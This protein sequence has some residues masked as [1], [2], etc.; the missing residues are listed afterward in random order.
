MYKI[1]EKFLASRALQIVAAAVCIMFLL[2]FSKSEQAPAP[3]QEK[4][5]LV[6]VQ[7]VV[8]TSDSP[9]LML[10]G[11][12]QS[13]QDAQLSAAI[14]S[15]VIEMLINDGDTVTKGSPLVKL[16]ARDTQLNLMT[17]EADLKEAT[18]QY[19]LS[20]VKQKQL[21]NAYDKEKVL[22]DITQSK[23][24]RS[25]N[26]YDQKSI[27]RNDFDS[28]TENLTRQ[29]LSVEQAEF[30]VAENNTRT[31]ELEAKILRFT[32]MR[33]KAQLDLERATITAPF[34]GIIS[35]LAISIGDRVRNGDELMRLQ[36]P[37]ALEV[38]TQIPSRYALNV[39]NNLQQGELIPATITLGNA[40]L[41]GKVIRVSGQTREGTGGVDAFI[42]FDTT[43]LGLSLGSTIRL[44]LDLPAV[45]NIIAVSAEAIYGENT[46][47]KIVDGRMQ[48]IEVD[49]IGEKTTDDGRTLVLI[50]SGQLQ[51]GEKV[52]LTKLSNASNGLL[53]K[54]ANTETPDANLADTQ[55]NE[56]S[57]T[58]P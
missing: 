28:A 56:M 36:N 9:S 33:D 19:K 5:W 8:P 35:D 51:Q 2:I 44:Q 32:A 45:D 12:V 57:A 58:S 16:D 29:Q 21:V 24:K 15:V 13:P 41:N 48:M 31:I 55:S 3:K 7:T 25:K 10:F 47:F 43:P 14:E 4:S 22:L 38:R 39:R 17:A 52:I 30:K 37:K 6:D 46:I 20:L 40:R 54:I 49:R 11:Q 50:R 18:A 23:Y 53:V 42:G 26:L 34:S 1:K 27:S